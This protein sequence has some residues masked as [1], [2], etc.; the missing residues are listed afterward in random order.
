MKKR[1]KKLKA[2]RGRPKKVAAEKHEHLVAL[3]LNKEEFKQLKTL[4][5]IFGFNKAKMMRHALMTY[6]KKAG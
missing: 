5:D 2:K 6:A 4:C 1:K 3:R